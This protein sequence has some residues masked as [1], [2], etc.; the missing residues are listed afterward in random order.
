MFRAVG[1]VCQ[2]SHGLP[3]VGGYLRDGHA[4]WATFAWYE[5][6]APSLLSRSK[7][8]LA[9]GLRQILKAERPS[10]RPSGPQCIPEAPKVSRGCGVP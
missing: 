6:D 7:K 8:A 10:S 2:G 1:C 4:L 5:R 3:R 9:D